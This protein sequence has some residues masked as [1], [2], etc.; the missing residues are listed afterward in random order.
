MKNIL[1]RAI[2]CDKLE[3][4]CDQYG[5]PTSAL[6]IAEIIEKYLNMQSLNNCIAPNEIFNLCSSGNTSWF[7]FADTILKQS[8]KIN[9]KYKTNLV[10]IESKQYKTLANRPKYSVLSNRKLSTYFDI[11]IQN[12]ECYL[13]YFLDTYIN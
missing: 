9:P 13:E 8:H 2:L 5:S 6:F 7:N 3:V 4:V 12:W 1:Q 10:T 11:D